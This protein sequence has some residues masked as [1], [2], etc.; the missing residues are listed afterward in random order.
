ML[1]SFAVKLSKVERALLARLASRGGKANAGRG[2]RK[3]WAKIPPAE[4]SKIMRKRAA[5]REKRRRTEKTK[6]KKK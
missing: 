6:R 4:R 2:A 3:A 1:D 5:V